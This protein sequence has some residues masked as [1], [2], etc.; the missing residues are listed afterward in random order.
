MSGFIDINLTS[1]RVL[2][3]T[4]TWKKISQLVVFLFIVALAWSGFETRE[5]IYNFI[6]QERITTTPVIRNISKLTSYDIDKAIEQSELIVSM[7]VTVV[8][9]QRNIR[10]I[11]YTGVDNVALK[12]IYSRFE[13]GTFKELPLFNNDVVNNKRIVDLINGEFSCGVY[14]ESLL[15]KML[16]ETGQYIKYSC[17]NGIP[18][19][20]GKFTGMVTVYTNR[21]PTPEE[22]DQLRAVLKHISSIIYDRD[23]K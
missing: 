9:F 18:P 13:L 1:V 23:F 2:L 7:Q 14:T 21:V 5:S 12:D 6:R 10:S 17:S 16:P 15:Y 19:F 11:V 4:L 22:V 3:N 8:D 20:Y